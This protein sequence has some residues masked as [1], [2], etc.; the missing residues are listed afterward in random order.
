MKNAMVVILMA[1]LSWNVPTARAQKPGVVLSNDPGWQKIGETEA[2]FKS[3]DESIA[4]LGADEFDAIKLKVEDAPLQ[5]DRLQVFYESGD[6]QEIDV[7]KKIQAGEESDAFKLDHPTRDIQKVAFTYHTVPNSSGE[8]ADVELYGLKPSKSSQAYR[9]DEERMKD[10][11]DG[12]KEDIR[13]ES[14]DTKR[15]I[16]RGADNTK[17]DVD[18]ATDKAG[19]DISEAAGKAAADIDDPKLDTKVGPD[20]QTIF[21]GDDSRYYY[22]NHEGKRV[23]VSWDKLKDKPEKD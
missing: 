14:S 4:V 13:R 12:T 18:R 8:K 9:K 10:K 2:S 20:G 17:R 5:I 7:K 19:N 16:E 23:Y 3:Q 15:D 21:V 11:A 22:V 1:L 6:M